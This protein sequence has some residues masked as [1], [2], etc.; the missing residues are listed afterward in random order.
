MCQ[1]GLGVSGAGL[2]SPRQALLDMSRV[3]LACTSSQGS[4][5]PGNQ[6]GPAEHREAITPVPPVL[7]VCSI[8]SRFSA[9]ED[10]HVT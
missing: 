4:H 3:R 6:P 10:T 5:S 2:S 9:L 8:P 7:S 1:A